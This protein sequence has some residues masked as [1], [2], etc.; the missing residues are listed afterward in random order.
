MLTKTLD[1]NISAGRE[2]KCEPVAL[3]S[4]VIC[5]GD[6]TDARR[7]EYDEN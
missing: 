5:S 2:K 1:G 4:S 3:I 6:W 7:R